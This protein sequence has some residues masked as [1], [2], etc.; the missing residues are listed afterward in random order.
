[1]ATTS[2]S[3]DAPNI[4]RSSPTQG[5]KLD[6]PDHL[7]NFLERAK[8]SVDSIKVTSTPIVPSHVLENSDNPRLADT[9]FK[10]SVALDFKSPTT[11]NRTLS[12]PTDATAKKA[13]FKAAI[14]QKAIEGKGEPK[15]DTS[16]FDHHIGRFVA[17]RFLTLLQL[18]APHSSSI[19][20]P[21]CR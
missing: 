7:K 17:A 1:M 5:R 8:F 10:H 19:L 21:L 3:T 16:S 6:N 2:K 13:S 18:F 20:S 15:L 11:P 12:S 9:N 14:Q 4:L